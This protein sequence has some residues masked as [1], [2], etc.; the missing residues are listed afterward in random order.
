MQFL[1]ESRSQ[2]LD[3]L[4]TMA[5]VLAVLLI[6]LVGW[7][8]LGDVL[9]I[10]GRFRQQILMFIFGALLAYLILPLVNLLQRFVRKR[11]AAVAGSYLLIFLAFILF[12][13]LLLNPF[14]SQARSLVNNMRNPAA[15]SLQSLD[16][17]RRDAQ[18]LYTTLSQQQQLI[19]GGRSPSPLAVHQTQAK[20]SMLQRHISNLL[21]NAPPAGQIR[22]PPSYVTPITTPAIQLAAAYTRATT[23]TSDSHAL[24]QA[25]TDAGQTVSAATAAYNETRGT[26]I[27]LLNLQ[28]WCD[29][30]SITVNLHDKFG[31]ALQQLSKQLAS[32]LNNALGIALQAGN[33]LLNT[34]L[35]L[36]ISVYFVSDGSRFVRWIVALAPEYARGRTAYFVDRL[37]QILGTY[38][39][40]Q[41]LLAVLAAG[42]DATGAVVIGIPYAVVI[43]FSS[44]LLSLIPVIGPVI[45]PF[46][47][48]LI[49]LIFTPLPK[50]FVFLVWLLIGE[51]LATNVI[52]PR[53]QGHRVGIHPL[54]AMAAALIGFPLAGF[55]GAFFAVPIVSF[56]H[57]VVQEALHSAQHNEAERP[58][59]GTNE[60]I[61]QAKSAG[62]PLGDM[63]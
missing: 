39:R 42:L 15:T 30:H 12:G 48:L 2:R 23:G 33:L 55:V 49:A 18:T 60:Q 32:I 13:V 34:V 31:N 37:D 45:L 16:T 25:V 24:Q 29:K 8:L 27:L 52:G 47:P 20:I 62:T 28:T 11:W 44:F 1:R 4:I 22:V 43:F 35:I 61:S 7:V 57:I 59:A 63:P 10:L 19:T 50:P 36:L 56:M 58:M 6:A 40:T 54:E 21:S 51:Q 41:V 53:V 38:L 5:C 17:V 14:I 3:A 26:P 46:P 9:G